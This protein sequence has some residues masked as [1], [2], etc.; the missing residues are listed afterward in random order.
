[1]L[2]GFFA[3]ANN[4]MYNRSQKNFTGVYGTNVKAG[5]ALFKIDNTVIYQPDPVTKTKR[6]AVTGIISNI[7]TQQLLFSPGLQ[8]FMAD[9]AG[10]V[11]PVSSKYLQANQTLGGPIE[12]KQNSPFSIDF[13]IDENSAPAKLTY[14]EDASSSQITIEL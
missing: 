11:Y 13:D 7:S 2:G 14:Q 9:K 8:I 1:M 6:I 4:H 12:S 5:N 3:F 10:K